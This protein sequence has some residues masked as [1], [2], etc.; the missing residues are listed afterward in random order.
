MRNHLD[1]D[2]ALMALIYLS[3]LARKQPLQKSLRQ[4]CRARKLICL[5]A[6]REHRHVGM[7]QL[8][9]ATQNSVSA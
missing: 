6:F 5:R 7:D 1:A 9:A 3:H 4:L 8:Y 2:A